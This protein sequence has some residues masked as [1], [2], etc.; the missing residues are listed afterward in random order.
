[1][2]NCIEI[3]L[4]QPHEDLESLTNYEVISVVIQKALSKIVDKMKK[5]IE[6]TAGDKIT[7]YEISLTYYVI[8]NQAK[9]FKF[10]ELNIIYYH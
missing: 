9:N 3:Q 4:D 8:I 7:I 1:M 2:R 6:L 10:S 5:D